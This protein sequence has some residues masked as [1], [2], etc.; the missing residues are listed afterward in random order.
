VRE[1]AHLE[2][3][4]VLSTVEE[5]VE[6]AAEVVATSRVEE[7]VVCCD[8]EDEVEVV[9]GG[10]EVV[11]GVAEVVLGGGEVVPGVA[12]VMVVEV[13][14]V[15]EVETGSGVEM[16]LDPGVGETAETGGS[17]AVGAG[18]VAAGG[19]EPAGELS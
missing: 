10:G 8:W 2:E 18:V 14:V 15:L 7:D 13:G 1:K 9:V 5:V 3:V 16:E 19:A 12:E 11:L 4:E 17:L 6:S